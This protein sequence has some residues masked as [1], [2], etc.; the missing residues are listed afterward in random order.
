M[1]RVL[2]TVLYACK[3]VL[4]QSHCTCFLPHDTDTSQHFGAL[5]LQREYVIV[6][7]HFWCATARESVK[8]SMGARGGHLS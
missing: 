8:P 5:L 7:Q 2:Y 1:L 3:A 4:P 6:Q